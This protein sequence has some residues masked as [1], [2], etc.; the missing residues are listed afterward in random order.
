M[1]AAALIIFRETLEAALFVG[2][3]AAATRGLVGRGRWL[4]S[5]IGA[6]VIG[7]IAIALLIQPI[8]Q[9]AEGIGQEFLNAGILAL[10]FVMLAWHVMS[11]AR[12]GMQMSS[13]ARQ[14]G[15]AVRDGARAP[16]ALLIA[17]ALTVLREGAE[18][19]LF[20]TGY[21]TGNA[22]TPFG[23]FVGCAL[24]MAAGVALGAVLYAGLKRIPLKRLFSVTNTMILLLAAA[25]AAQLA[26][27]L[28][29]A[30]VLPSLT[31]PLWNTEHWLPM[32]SVPGL[33]LHALIGYDAQPSGMQVLFYV[34]GLVLI[35][36][37]SR[38]MRPRNGFKA[39]VKPA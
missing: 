30:G 28:V 15:S 9:M 25:M 38:L 6:G 12:H 23:I 14:L 31:T 39:L 8:S 5:G 26:R 21:L 29:Q 27:T 33:L 18:T 32:A 35:I 2:L 34:G 17:V 20:I 37:G 11:S 16:W 4:A 1:F 22:A 3:I 13:E 24:G 36:C 7:S 10:A 19:V